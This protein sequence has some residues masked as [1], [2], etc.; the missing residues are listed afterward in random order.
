MIERCPL[1]DTEAELLEHPYDPLKSVCFDCRIW[2]IANWEEPVE[3]IENLSNL[4][5]AIFNK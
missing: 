4:G 3:V 1:C 2:L 5:D